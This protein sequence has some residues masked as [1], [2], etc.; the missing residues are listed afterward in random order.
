MVK[1]AAE[2]NK[3]GIFGGG[4][5]ERVYGLID[6]RDRAKVGEN[7]KVKRG[8]VPA[9]GKGGELRIRGGNCGTLLTVTL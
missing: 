9:R 1:I 7:D 8:S 2:D 6:F 5:L 3:G 4:M